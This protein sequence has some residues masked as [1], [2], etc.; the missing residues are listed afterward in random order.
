MKNLA[1]QLPEALERRTLSVIAG[2]PSAR[3]ANL[4][5][6]GQ[7]LAL[8]GALALF[9]EKGLAPDFWACCDPQDIIANYIPENP[10][11]STIYYVAS[12]CHPVVFEKLNGCDVRIWHVKDHP[13]KGASHVASASSITICA[14]WLFD[15][16]GYTDFEYYGWDGCFIDGK[17][18]ATDDRD[19]LQPIIYINYGGTAVGDEVIGGRTFTT[20]RT[21]A[22]EAKEA[23]Q[24][25]QF[26]EYFDMGIKIHGNGM[27]ECARQSLW[28]PQAK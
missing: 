3:D 9:T 5:A 13:T 10:P 22:A 21:W 14:T 11:K 1:L 27:F 17:H 19:W 7:T 16:L 26:A 25:F 8:N 6:I 4:S 23:G 28:E 24:L 15:R 2:G 12:K 18:H 20:T